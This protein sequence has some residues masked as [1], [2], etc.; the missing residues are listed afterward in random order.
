MTKILSTV[1]FE[2]ASA[3]SLFRAMRADESPPDESI[4]DFRKEVYEL[5]NLLASWMQQDYTPFLKD[6]ADIR[7]D[8]ESLKQAIR[9][10]G[11]LIGKDEKKC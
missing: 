9:S 6:L 8:I 7:K 5:W 4:K 10:I 11:A 1:G 3:Q 2:L